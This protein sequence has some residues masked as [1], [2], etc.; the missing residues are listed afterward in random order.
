MPIRFLPGGK[1]LV[2]QKDDGL[3]VWEVETGT[4]LIHNKF[5][6]MQY[7][8]L[9]IST[10]G[11]RIAGVGPG[12]AGEVW[13]WEWDSGKAPRM[14]K[15]GLANRFHSVVF[16]PDGK[17]LAVTDDMAG[18]IQLIDAATGK[19]LRTFQL[20][21]RQRLLLHVAFTPD[22]KRLLGSDDGGR[23]LR[24]KK[25]GGVS[26]R[27]A[28]TGKVPTSGRFRRRQSIPDIRERTIRRGPGLGSTGVG[29]G[30]GNP[31][32]E[33]RAGESTRHRS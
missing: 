28:E 24:G 30:D 4:E 31:G 32:V 33:L 18:P 9:D 27:D 19:P 11:K 17:H 3:A 16:S 13:V 14:L 20:P 10:D 6:I 5:G 21:D 8:E 26:G 12:Y 1:E 25:E 22:G 7:T 29:T 23:N 15:T 2:A